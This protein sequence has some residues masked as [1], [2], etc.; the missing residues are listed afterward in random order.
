MAESL[1]PSRFLFRFAVPCLHRDPLWS[2][3]TGELPEEFRLPALGELEGRKT[4][5]DVRAAWSQEGL[6]FEV[7]SRR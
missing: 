1:L 4:F 5:A 2:D 7:R 3:A 6:A